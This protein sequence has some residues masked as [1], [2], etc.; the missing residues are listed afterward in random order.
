MG[1]PEKSDGAAG[2]GSNELNMT[3]EKT[4]GLLLILSLWSYLGKAPARQVAAQM[5]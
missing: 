4:R 2:S 1:P 5:S 3:T